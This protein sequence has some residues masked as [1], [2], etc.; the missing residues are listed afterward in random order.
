MTGR[1]RADGPLLVD[2]RDVGGVRVE[3][4]A[5]V[6]TRARGLL[7]RR[8]IDGA[9]LIA[10]CSSVHGLM[11]RFDLEVAY[12][13]ADGRVLSVKPL[14]RWRMHGHQRGAAMVLEAEPGRLLRWGVRPGAVVGV[15]S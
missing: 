3:V 11:M 12:L 9:M 5:T 10:P 13:D 8:G 4:A 15:G 14:P 1:P 6:A 2:G 7:G